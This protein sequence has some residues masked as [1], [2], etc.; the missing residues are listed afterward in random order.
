MYLQSWL[1]RLLSS[2]K[3]VKIHLHQTGVVKPVMQI[4]AAQR[5]KFQQPIWVHADM[6]K[7]PN[8]PDGTNLVDPATFSVSTC[9]S[10]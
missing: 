4:L 2:T 7:G 5:D 8:M 6:L 1:Q 10:P 3:G 9:T